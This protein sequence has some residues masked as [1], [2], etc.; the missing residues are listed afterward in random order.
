MSDPKTTVRQQRY[1]QANRELIKDPAVIEEFDRLAAFLLGSQ[2]GLG[3]REV[4]RDLEF[5]FDRLPTFEFEFEPLN[6]EG[7]LV[8]RDTAGTAAYA[9]AYTAL[10]ALGADEAAAQ[11]AGDAAGTAAESEVMG[12]QEGTNAYAGASGGAAEAAA[13]IAA[14]NDTGDE[15][16]RPSQPPTYGHP[17]GSD[18]GGGPLG[19]DPGD[20][21]VFETQLAWV[22]IPNPGAPLFR[23]EDLAFCPIAGKLIVV[24]HLSSDGKAYQSADDGASWTELVVPY[25]TSQFNGVKGI[26]LA[27]D[28]GHVVLVTATKIYE[29]DID[30]VWTEILPTNFS[31][32]T[33]V[34]YLPGIGFCTLNSYLGSP[35]CFLSNDGYTWAQTST[36]PVAG[37][38][39]RVGGGYFL[40]LGT[41]GVSLSTDGYIWSSA[42]P[43]VG[44]GTAFTDV[45]YHPSLGVWFGVLSAS[46]SGIYSTPTKIFK[47]TLANGEEWNIG[48]P[49]YSFGDT[50]EVPIGVGGLIYDTHSEKLIISTWTDVF[51]TSADGGVTWTGQASPAPSISADKS[52]VGD[53]VVCFANDDYIFVG[54]VV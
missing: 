24:G 17:L 23:R 54:T 49:V 29:K 43:G 45:T 13:R 51:Y 38:K 20:P 30:D 39:I 5:G 37:T 12:N 36:T 32:C 8:L 50:G 47:S 21:L 18:P 40:R 34:G 26:D 3:Q 10:I 42:S 22:A 15:I 11:A 35:C 6:W 16:L 31:S 27:V 44:F 25:A 1:V 41:A 46:G 19:P 28:R 33:G 48:T 9:A 4:E 53:N 52:C 7:T 2:S 14:G